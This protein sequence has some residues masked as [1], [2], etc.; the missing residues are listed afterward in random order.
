LVGP[1]KAWGD[2]PCGPT[3]AIM[4]QVVEPAHWRCSGGAGSR[5][6]RD[7]M[8]IVDEA[9]KSG[10]PKFWLASKSVRPV[11]PTDHLGLAHIRWRASA[12]WP[13]QVSM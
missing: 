12:S 8:L 6:W 7:A 4:A 3:G 11:Q 2:R 9:L 1:V 10:S 13:K 5:W